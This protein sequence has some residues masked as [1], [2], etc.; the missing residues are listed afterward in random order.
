VTIAVLRNRWMVLAVCG[1]LVLFVLF[2]PADFKVRAMSM[3][4][5]SMKSN[6]SRIH[7]LT[8]GWQMFLDYPVTGTGDIDLRALYETYIV[9]IDPGE[10]GHLHNNFMMLLVTLGAVGFIATT[11]MF[12]KIFALELGAAG[13]T[14]SHWLYGSVAAGSIAAYVGFLVN[15]LFE[16]NFGDHEIAVFLWFTVGLALAAQ[17]LA[18]G[19]EKR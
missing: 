7:M 14:K 15:G 2:A 3:F 16:W 1:L 8:T 12:V 9:P 6:L 11:A 17:R 4:D 10:G 19:G 13:A 18:T 5:P